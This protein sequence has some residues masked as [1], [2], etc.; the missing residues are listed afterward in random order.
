MIKI[1]IKIQE[2][3]KFKKSSD[4]TP[5]SGRDRWLDMYVEQVRDGIIKGLSKD[6]KVNITNN[7]EKALRDSIVIRPSDK[8]SGVVIMNR[9]DYETEVHDELK[10]N[11]TYKE[12]KED[13]TKKIENKIKKNVE[14]MY[15]RN[16]I[17]K[18]MKG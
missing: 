6:F 11:G 9:S 2:Y 12:I 15:K 7:E 1:K 14:G 4:W 13:L 18:E 8:S 16:V 5:N 17:T 3:S 10:D